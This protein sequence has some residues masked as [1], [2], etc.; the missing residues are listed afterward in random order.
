MRIL[1]LTHE[2]PPVGGGGGHVAKDLCQGLSELGHEIKILTADILGGI[3]GESDNSEKAYE[4]IRL[5]TLRK[6]PSRAN[7]LAMISY[8]IV[9]V[10]RGFL[11]CMNWRPDVIHVHFAVPAGPISWVLSKLTGI[12]YVL[13]VHL[14]D[15]PGGTP[16]KTDKWFRFIQPLT[17][18]IWNHAKQVIAVS[19]F[20]RSLAQ[21]H[22]QVPINVI[23]NG[24]DIR[25]FKPENN[26]VHDPLKIIFAGRFVPQKNPILVIQTLAE[27]SEYSWELVMLGDGPLYKETVG[28]I[29][30]CGLEDRIKIPGWVKPEE[31][32]KEF[33][34]SDILFLPSKSEG[35]PVVGV[36]ALASG[37]AFLVSD[38]GGFGDIVEQGKNGFRISLEEPDYKNLFINGLSEM[39]GNTDKLLFFKENS[40]RMAEKFDI[41]EITKKYD[42]ILNQSARK[43]G[44]NGKKVP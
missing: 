30:K 34:N 13:T 14:G 2:F 35:L 12:P 19:Q 8:I 7:M 33:Q 1:V 37:L 40:I 4:I 29:R 32:K 42:L 24:V 41:K 26:I 11:L 17:F 6:D 23:H 10:F 21:K 22:Y 15:I 31:V 27:L 43:N 20:S 9:S 28:E 36:Q 38:I 25:K 39:I 16:E 44:P 3:N 18:P 5:P